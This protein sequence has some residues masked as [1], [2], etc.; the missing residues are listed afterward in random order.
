MSDVWQQFDDWENSERSAADEQSWFDMKDSMDRSWPAQ[1]SSNDPRSSGSEEESR[2]S[3]GS[4]KL[5]PQSLQSPIPITSFNSRL[6]VTA[7]GQ[8]ASASGHRMVGRSFYFI[9]LCRSR[10]FLLTFLLQESSSNTKSS[11]SPQRTSSA[12]TWQ[13]P[14]RDNPTADVLS[15]DDP[16]DE[17]EVYSGSEKDF[18]I[19]NLK[20]DAPEDE[21]ELLR[22]AS[23]ALP[24]SFSSNVKE[25]DTTM[26][27]R[28]FDETVQTARVSDKVFGGQDWQEFKF[29]QSAT[30]DEIDARIYELILSEQDENGNTPLPSLEYPAPILVLQKK[31]QE[32]AQSHMF[33]VKKHVKATTLQRRE[34]TRD[35][36]DYARALGMGKYHAN[37]EVMQARAAY[38][39][40][41]G[42]P[43]GLRLDESDDESTLGPEINDAV[44]YVTCMANG[45]Q[46]GPVDP[47]G[48]WEEITRLRRKS[49]PSESPTKKRKLDVVDAHIA[50]EDFLA[51]KKTEGD[52]LAKPLN[53]RQR[54][55]QKKLKI[56]SQ[57]LN[58]KATAYAERPHVSISKRERKR[59]RKRQ[60]PSLSKVEK[61]HVR[62]EGRRTENTTSKA[63]SAGHLGDQSVSNSD[64]AKE[65]ET[66][67]P[68]DKGI[69]V[70]KPEEKSKAE[71]PTVR[72]QGFDNAV[73]AD[74][75]RKTKKKKK[76]KK[77][78][79][80]NPGGATVNVLGSKNDETQDAKARDSIKASTDPPNTDNVL[81]ASKA[82]P[83]DD[84]EAVQKD[85]ADDN[86]AAIPLSELTSINSNV[87]VQ[88]RRDRGI[89]RKS[90][91]TD[92]EVAPILETED[93]KDHHS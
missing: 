46:R 39:L 10:I 71:N 74:L 73:I 69:E 47:A 88:V 44:E 21:V 14:E 15:I 84:K 81:G 49:M 2:I 35:I 90:A 64:F 55:R 25:W 57:S 70:E 20:N 32:F 92:S 12:E 52:A 53:S 4:V 3:A 37:L 93:S 33:M 89:K 34:F 43:G 79:R 18:L 61:A 9:L 16:F 60:L 23:R 24:A 62:S 75:R 48:A 22:R 76:K 8:R 66:D 26:N 91:K 87:K 38:R 83:E 40:D 54:R 68:K 58:H 86:A 63:T 30:P 78:K 56:R 72:N 45:M 1:D 65:K 42:L 13:Y 11:K 31:V 27:Q 50:N 28:E 5:P 67:I 59:G 41:R 85:S 17:F 6:K 80:S 7:R 77:R 82:A 36:Y 29:L 51:F 19:S